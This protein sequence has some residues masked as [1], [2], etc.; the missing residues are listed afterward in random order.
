MRADRLISILL[1]LQTRGRFSAHQLAEE[2]EVSERT[3]YR[4]ITAMGRFP[5]EIYKEPIRGIF[6]F[7]IPVAV[8]TSFPV[9]ALIGKLSWQLVCLSFVISSCIFI[10]AMVLWKS[11]LK[12]YQS[13][14]G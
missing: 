8:M 5:M 1:L 12:R 9:Q 2:L 6:T 14:G 11:A 3:I 10:G 4:D 7:V 13:W